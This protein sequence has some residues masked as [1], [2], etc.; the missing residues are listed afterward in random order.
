MSPTLQVSRP[1]V[2]IEQS[3]SFSVQVRPAG[4]WSVTAR[5]VA[6]P[7]PRFSTLIEKVAVSP[8]LMPP[9][10][11]VLVTLTS[12]HRTVTESLSLPV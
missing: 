2:L 12:A 9:S 7:G 1:L 3:A 11:G 6:L 5:T 8:A 4:S 10:F